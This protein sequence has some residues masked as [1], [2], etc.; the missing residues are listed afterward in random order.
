MSNL[1]K[2]PCCEYE[3]SRGSDLKRHVLRRHKKENV[4]FLKEY[5]VLYPKAKKQDLSF[6]CLCCGKFHKNPKEKKKFCNRSC[7]AK[8]NNKGRVVSENQ[9]KK[10]SIKLKKNT[11]QYIEKVFMSKKFKT[12]KE[13]RE[14][15]HHFYNE[16]LKLKKTNPKIYK[17]LSKL[18]NN[19]VIEGQVKSL[20]EWKKDYKIIKSNAKKCKT[21][22]EF[23]HKYKSDYDKARYAKEQGI[24]PNIFD[25]IYSHMS[26]VG[27]NKKRCIYAI[28]FPKLKKIYIGLTCNH[29]SRFN[30]HKNK[31][32]NRNVR[33]LIENNEDYKMEVMVDY[34]PSH[35]ASQKEGE[36]LKKFNKLGW[37]TLNSS[38][39]G[40]LGGNG[41]GRAFQIKSE[42]IKCIKKCS[43]L[44]EFKVKYNVLWRQATKYKVSNCISY[45]FL[46]NE[47]ELQYELEFMSNKVFNN[48]YGSLFDRR[49]LSKY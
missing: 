15:N 18:I 16:Y 29:I 5:D 46:Q 48:T 39:T 1:K 6:S 33:K 41:L 3:T 23:V 32:S 47:K 20:E 30:D 45:Y 36:L 19:T 11:P 27:S 35:D 13:L 7:A 38:K 31:S 4:K 26:I 9:R 8:Y 24:F 43:S 10:V 49:K 12:K 28:K 37:I 34:M 17:R 14:Y 42:V 2:C 25:D 44:N 22:S 40:G 21:R